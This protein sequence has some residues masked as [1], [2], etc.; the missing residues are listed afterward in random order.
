MSRALDVQVGGSHYKNL[1][2]Q[3]VVF[4]ERNGLSMAEASIVKYL[5]RCEKKGGAEDFR[6]AIHFSELLLELWGDRSELFLSRSWEISPAVYCRANMLGETRSRLI[7]SLF[8]IN[9]RADAERF[10]GAMRLAFSEFY[11][12]EFSE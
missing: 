9:S 12:M 6:K 3:P 1:A 8:G 2:I 11:P 5:T 10:V 7:L 4:A